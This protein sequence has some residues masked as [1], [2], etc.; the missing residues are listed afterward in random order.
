MSGG[1]AN[2][3]R[4]GV[5]AGPEAGEGASALPA[6][7]RI[8][9]VG[10]RDGFQMERRFIPTELKIEIVEALAAAGLAEIEAASFVRPDVVPQMRDAESVIGGLADAT[11]ERVWALVPNRRGAERARACGVS[12]LH[13][14]V[15]VSETYN[16][17]NVGLSVD[18][19]LAALEAVVRSAAEAPGAVTV[20]ATLAATFGCPF[21]GQLPEERIVD[22]ARRVRDLGVDELG[23]ADSV[24]LGTPPLVRRISRGVREAV[25]E[26]PLRLHLHDTRGLGM[27][28][29]IAGI[30]EGISA[31]DTSLGGLGGCPMVLGAS[32]NVATEDLVNLCDELEID[33]GIDLDGVRAASGRLASFLDRELP[34]RV[35]AS[36]TRAELLARNR[37]SLQA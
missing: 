26:L 19:S 25:G 9:E 2:P 37:E 4:S 28:N 7:L 11:R 29:A 18:E 6:R 36:G 31:L 16:R 33:T 23:L 12:R 8:V 1:D 35:L 32:G 27:A 30:E 14:V 3:T 10:P 5:A 17:R 15:C 34:S 13:F 20:A 21:E 24:G 22:L